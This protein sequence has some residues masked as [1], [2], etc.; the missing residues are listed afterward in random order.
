MIL[1]ENIFLKYWSPLGFKVILYV[2]Y[3]SIYI[4]ISIYICFFEIFCCLYVTLS[5]LGLAYPCLSHMYPELAGLTVA[6]LKNS[7]LRMWTN[8]T[9]AHPSDWY[10]RLLGN[11]MC[12]WMNEWGMKYVGADTNSRTTLNSLLER[13]ASRTTKMV[14]WSITRE[15]FFRLDVLIIS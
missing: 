13:P 2:S 3:L 6:A 8:S 15:T 10:V 9:A 12:C 1:H 14:T 5:L 4:N 7:V 11:D